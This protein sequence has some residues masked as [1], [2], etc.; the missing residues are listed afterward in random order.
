M[1]WK[2]SD[3]GSMLVPHFSTPA[4]L[5]ATPITL[6]SV[7]GLNDSLPERR[8]DQQNRNRYCQ[9]FIRVARFPMKLVAF[10]SQKVCS[11]VVH[12]LIEVAMAV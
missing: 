2:V 9:G 3:R 11:V 10:P 1:R 4:T 12:R 6:K 8:L 7:G 5:E